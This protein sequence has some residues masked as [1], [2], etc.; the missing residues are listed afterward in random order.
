[1]DEARRIT[2]H[3]VQDDH[4][5]DWLRMREVLYTGVDRAFH[6]QEMDIFHQD[7]SKQCFLAVSEAA[8]APCGF[9]E[10]TLRNIVDGCLTSPVGYVEGIYVDPEIR[11]SGIGRQLL[12]RAEE[13]CRSMGC[14]EMGIDAELD[15]TS[16]QQ[17][18]EHMGFKETYRIVEYRKSLSES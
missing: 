16:A 8:Q 6:L 14:T 7:E 13:W 15:D 2:I 17:F 9:I 11:Q 12:F 4:H 1:M 18:H 5:A 10:V 3:A